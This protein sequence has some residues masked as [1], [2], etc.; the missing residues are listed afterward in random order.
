MLLKVVSNLIIGLEKVGIIYKNNQILEPN[1]KLLFL[2]NTQMI[3]QG[4]SDQKIIGPNI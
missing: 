3:S 4:F 1:D 2:Q